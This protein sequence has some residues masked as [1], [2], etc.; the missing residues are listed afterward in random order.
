MMSLDAIRE[1][2]DELAEQ[3]EL[4]DLEPREAICDG[5]ET[6]KYMPAIG[7]Y[8][9]PGFT[10]TNEYFCDSSGFGSPNEPALTFEQF[11]TTVKKGRFYAIGDQGQLQLYVR[12]FKLDV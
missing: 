12:E 1:L 3:A 10:Q 2:S 11:L 8:D 7:S 5:D 6:V 9:P 4:N